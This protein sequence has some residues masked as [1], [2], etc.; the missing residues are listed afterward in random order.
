[1]LNDTGSDALTVFDSD[2]LALAI[3]PT[4][5]RF[6]PIITVATAGGTVWR[7]RII[8]E[9]QLIDLEGNAVS[10]WISEYGII[11]PATSGVAR[12]SG[13]EMRQSLYFATAPGNQHLFVAEKKNRIVEQLPVV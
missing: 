5:G 2:I 8:I 12:L 10:D 4:Y 6:G 3:P 7:Q 9:I 11:T 1:M 13:T